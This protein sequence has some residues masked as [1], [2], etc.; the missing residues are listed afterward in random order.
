MQMC[1]LDSLGE[2]FFNRCSKE[3]ICPQQGLLNRVKLGLK[4]DS[5]GLSWAQKSL[6][7][8]TVITE[9]IK[10]YSETRWDSKMVERA[11]IVFFRLTGTQRFIE[12][13]LG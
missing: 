7:A 13:Q 2:K 9:T 8:L 12:V 6:K 3:F 1:S 4:Y 11:S 10:G 5:H